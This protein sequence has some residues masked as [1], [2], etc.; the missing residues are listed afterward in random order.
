MKEII[1]SKTKPGALKRG[2]SGRM[3]NPQGL[4]LPVGQALSIPRH[5]PGTRIGGYRSYSL[6]AVYSLRSSGGTGLCRV[7]QA[8][9]N[10]LSGREIHLAG[11]NG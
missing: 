2:P 10:R 11:R 5:G 6:G 8:Q 9:F 7:G 1:P 3:R 4:S